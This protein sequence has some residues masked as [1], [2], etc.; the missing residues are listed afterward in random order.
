MRKVGVVVLGIGAVLLI[1]YF[2]FYYVTLFALNPDIPVV[3]RL[4][5]TAIPVGLLLILVS[6]VR[7]R[8]NDMR[9]ETF[10]EVD[11]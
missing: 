7:E 11:K 6:L 4:A 8:V 3:L 1:G 5:F 10:K 9:R 2:G